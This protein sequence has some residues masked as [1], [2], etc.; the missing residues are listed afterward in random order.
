[1]LLFALILG[2]ES[3]DLFKGGE[4]ALRVPIFSIHQEFNVIRLNGKPHLFN[5]VLVDCVELPCKEFGSLHDIVILGISIL[6]D[7]V[8]ICYR[9]L[10]RF[11]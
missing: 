1:M 8:E 5:K 4:D 6:A 7:L 10:D 3:R 11:D 9:T 2:G